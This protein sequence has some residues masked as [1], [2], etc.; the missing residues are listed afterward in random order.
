MLENHFRSHCA[1]YFT[2]LVAMSGGVAVYFTLSAACLVVALR[3]V[4]KSLMSVF[5]QL[6]TV[7][8]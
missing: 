2:N 4:I 7:V 6:K 8:T 5:E 1:H 3:A